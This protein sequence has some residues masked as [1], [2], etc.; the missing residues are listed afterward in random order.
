MI[1]R[2]LPHLCLVISVMILVFYG[3]DRVNHAMNF[4]GNPVFNTLLLV[5]ALLVIALS[6]LAIVRDRRGS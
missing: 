1:R 5:Y 4:I 3:I 6:V 2:A